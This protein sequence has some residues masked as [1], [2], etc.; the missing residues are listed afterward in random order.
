MSEKESAYSYQL[1]PCPTCN[2]SASYQVNLPRGAM[3]YVTCK[4]CRSSIAIRTNMDCQIERITKNA[5]GNSVNGGNKMKTCPNC[6][7]ELK[8]EAKFCGGCGY[9]FPVEASA[10][11][12][13]IKCPNC[14]NLLKPGAKFCGKCGTKLDANAPQKSNADITKQASFIQWNVLPGQLA[15][16]IDSKEIAA[17]GRVKGVVV[18][19]G[20]RAL[21]FVNGK[22][23][24]ELGSGSYEFKDFPDVKIAANGNDEEKKQS[25]ISTFF[26]NIKNFFKNSPQIPANVQNVS[27]VLV[28]STEFPLVFAIKDVATSGIRSEVGLHLL[29]KISNI[30]EFYA[31]ELLD[32][33]FVS[34]EAIKNK[35]EPIVKT[36]LNSSLGTITPDKVALAGDSVLA[37]LQAQ[38]G[39]IYSYV[40]VSKIIS[41][42]ATNEELEKIRKM[43]EELY[44]SEL[45]LTELTKRNSFLNRL[46]DENNAQALREARSQTDFQ[47]AMDKIDQDRELNDDERLKFSQM[48]E[49]QR[50]IREAKT[51]DEIDAAMVV[52]Q[53][54]GMLRDEELDNVRAQVE[55]NAALRD[56]NYEQALNLATLANEKELDRQNLQWEIEIGNKRL[57][58]EIA[59]ERMQ[60]EF[61]DER[62]HKEME[63]D[64]EEQL[65]QLEL[66]RQAQAIRNEREEAE[67]KRQMESN[68]QKIAHEEEMRRM[69][70][71]MTA[72]QIVAANPDITPEAAAAMAEKF[73]AE[74]AAAA[75]DKTAEMAMKQSADMQAFMK[76]QMQMMRDMAVAGMGMNAQNQQ[77]MM[78]AKDAEMNRF[79]GGVNNA[80]N[81]VAGA[82]KNP[83]TVVQGVPGGVVSTGSTTATSGAKAAGV[84]PSCGTPHEPGAIFCENCGNSL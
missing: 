17:Y 22:I 68:A 23:T 39:Q 15:L 21:F 74:A 72:E 64:K 61:E 65:T 50:L 47:A 37:A 76:E 81:S 27:I 32:K 83:N 4:Y 13:E 35:V 30:N 79:A 38:I 73:K 59:R 26:N 66:L 8:D 44:V 11:N 62:R 60:A 63:M 2:Q 52:F 40:Q 36:I 45:E 51:Q 82:L 14:G 29:C 33:A 41:L 12:V 24:A 6:G 10:S 80:V 3:L 5:E 78:A 42:T 57:E 16:K 43:Q 20:L 28:R 67:H 18:Q 46:Q 9:K 75:N 69:F 77:N 55:Q 84:C 56:L 58:N 70:Q 19:E 7:K 25:F 31:N 54:S 48:L 71:N 1:I 53:K 34:F 49:A